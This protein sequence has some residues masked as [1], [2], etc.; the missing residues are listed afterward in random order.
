MDDGIKY[1]S[2]EWT[3]KRHVDDGIKWER[4]NGTEDSLENGVLKLV[5]DDG[6]IM[7]INLDH[8]SIEVANYRPCYL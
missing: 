8:P 7:A 5:L 6:R 2:G 1:S 3:I 4:Y